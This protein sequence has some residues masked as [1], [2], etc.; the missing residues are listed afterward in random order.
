MII[1]SKV[2]IQFREMRYKAAELLSQKVL[3]ET[4]NVYENMQL[5]NFIALATYAINHFDTIGPGMVKPRFFYM[6]FLHVDRAFDYAD[7]IDWETSEVVRKFKS[8]FIYNL[9]NAFRIIPFFRFRLVARVLIALS[10][11]S[12]KLGITRMSKRFRTEIQSYRKLENKYE[13][14]ADIYY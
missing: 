13:Q 11:M 1:L 7:Y 4:E 9:H 10:K 12:I 3:D 6:M 2:L 14:L 8:R 5:Y